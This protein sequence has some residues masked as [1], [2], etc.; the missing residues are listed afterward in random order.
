MKME[1]NKLSNT[2]NTVLTKINASDIN[3]IVELCSSNG[4]SLFKLSH[5]LDLGNAP[6]NSENLY[7][8]PGE[9]FQIAEEV[10]KR[11]P[12]YTELAFDILS[13][14]PIFLDFIY[15]KYKTVFPIRMS[16]CKA[17]IK[18]IYVDPNGGISPCLATS[19]GFS[20][21]SNGYYKH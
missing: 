13:D 8:K 1:D 12:N 21:F 14:K 3:N 2:Q 9:E 11:T 16:G 19:A 4:V 18:E 20:N 17:C 6:H 5:L 10:I 7:L 15:K